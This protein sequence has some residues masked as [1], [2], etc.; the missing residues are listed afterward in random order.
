MKSGHF[1]ESIELLKKIIIE[2]DTSEYLNNSVELLYSNFQ[3]KDSTSRQSNR[4]LLFTDLGRFLESEMIRHSNNNTSNSFIDKSYSFYLMCLTKIGNLTEAISG[5]ENIMESHPEQTR[6]LLASWDRSALMLLVNGS[7][8][9]NNPNDEERKDRLF[10]DKP[11]HRIAKAL[12]IKMTNN[13]RDN[14]SKSEGNEILI[15]QNIKK[16]DP[17][18]QFE[19]DRKITDDLNAILEIRTENYIDTKTSHP[20]EFKLHQNYPNPFNPT[21]TI[22]FQIPSSTF[23]ELK[24]Y[25]V[26][27]KEIITLVNDFKSPG[28]YEVIFDARVHGHATN[29]SSGIY[30]YKLG[31]G[32]FI[33]VRKM[34]M[35]K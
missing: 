6:R 18:N 24:V 26:T 15:E 29:L 11:A 25:D 14:D 1:D 31:A 13:K 5:Y 19:L 32:D 22:M 20:K 3:L 9:S 7:G 35:I 4:S 12:F 30:F 27:G 23:V 21:T 28:E 10:K 8:G 17:M 16:F 34:M 33:Q 2:Y